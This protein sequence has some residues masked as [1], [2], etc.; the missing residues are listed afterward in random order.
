MINSLPQ[1][2][3]ELIENN[4]KFKMFIDETRTERNK[5]VPRKHELEVINGKELKESNMTLCQL[6]IDN[7]ISGI[8][9]RRASREETISTRSS[10][11]AQDYLNNIEEVEISK[12]TAAFKK[13]YVENDDMLLAN[14]NQKNTAFEELSTLKVEEE[15]ILS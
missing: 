2:L 4:F 5:L 15:N 8:K 6:R 7:A 9:E 10:E 11:R 1:E 12:A 14:L 13:S 3:K